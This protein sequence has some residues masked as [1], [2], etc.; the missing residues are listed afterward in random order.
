MFVKAFPA[1]AAAA[2]VGT[3]HQQWQQLTKAQ[4]ILRI[5]CYVT[6]CIKT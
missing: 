1:A 2:A 3:E 4:K 5:L 6:L